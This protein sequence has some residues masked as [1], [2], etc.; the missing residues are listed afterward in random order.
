M[1]QQRGFDRPFS[2][3]IQEL[4]EEFS[5]EFA[6]IDFRRTVSPPVRLV[7]A[8]S[9]THLPELARIGEYQS[10]FSLIQ[11]QMI[12]FT[13]LEV[14]R[15]DV[16]FTRHSEVDAEPAP[17]VFASPGCFRV[18]IRKFKQHLFAATF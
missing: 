3:S 1:H 14:G 15:S 18:L 12:V 4:V 2:M 6:R 16:R 17:N 13:R 11:N 5:I 8:V 7:F 10:A 9:K